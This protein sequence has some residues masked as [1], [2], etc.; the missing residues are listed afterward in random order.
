MNVA[1]RI[2]TFGYYAFYRLFNAPLGVPL[3]SGAAVG[4]TLA[5]TDRITATASTGTVTGVLSSAARITVAVRI[6]EVTV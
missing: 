4:V 5:G 3:L 2:F 6:G 1:R